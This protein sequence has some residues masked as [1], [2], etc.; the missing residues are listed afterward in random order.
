[1][2]CAWGLVTSSAVGVVVMQAS[3]WRVEMRG[4]ESTQGGEV[5]GVGTRGGRV[6]VGRWKTWNVETRG[7]WE[8]VEFGNTWSKE[9]MLSAGDTWGVGIK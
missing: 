9:N 7:A 6:H 3:G 4:V 1:M 8:H 2:T 5:R